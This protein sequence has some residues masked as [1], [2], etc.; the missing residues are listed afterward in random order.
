MENLGPLGEKGRALL[1]LMII[2]ALRRWMLSSVESRPYSMS[3]DQEE[4][5]WKGLES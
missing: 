3:E 4:E 5:G 1:E 2:R